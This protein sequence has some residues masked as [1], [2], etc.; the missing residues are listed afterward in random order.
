MQDLL[1][2]Y[3]NATLKDICIPR[4][5]D[6]GIYE[7]NYCLLGNGCNTQTQYLDMKSMLESGVRLFDVRPVLRDGILWTYH[8]TGCGGLGCDGASLESFLQQ[9]KDYLDNHKELVLFDFSNFCDVGSQDAIFLNLLN[10]ILQDRIYTDDGSNTNLFMNRPIQ[11]ILGQNETKGKIVLMMD[12]LTSASEN[13]AEGYFAH[14]YFRES[15]SYA[16][17]FEFDEMLADQLTK[18][19][20]YDENSNTVF[21]LS[22]TLT[23]NDSLA[24]DCAANPETATSIESL[25][26]DARSKLATTIDNWITNQ[27]I[28]KGKIPNILSIDYAN[29]TVTEQCIKISKFNLE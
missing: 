22:Y 19:N 6:A 25:S 23:L 9:T 26:I 1:E 13:R 3:P 16:N 28:T 18:F 12:G 10:N 8:A 17:K 2:T 29:T 7:L 5:H 4:A 27:I 14:S 21:S 20:N 24:F 11:D 15:G